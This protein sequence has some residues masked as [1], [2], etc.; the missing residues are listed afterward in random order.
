MGH[1][2]SL[3]VVPLFNIAGYRTALTQHAL[4]YKKGG[5]ITLRHNELRD[6]TAI[7]LKEIC[8]DVRT[9]L[10]LVEVNREVFCETIANTRPEA[11]HD[12]SALGFWTPDH[13]VF[14]DIRVFNLQ[15]QRFRCLELNKR[16]ER[17]EK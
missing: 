2:G 8:H 6:I 5:L 14:F 4:S 1:Y 7:L 17:N 12:I 13:R 15:A 11:R 3:W 10:T 9:E 16:F